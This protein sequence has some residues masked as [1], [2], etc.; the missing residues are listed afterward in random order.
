[1]QVAVTKKGIEHGEAKL[2]KAIKAEEAAEQ[3]I[4]PLPHLL[5]LTLTLT[6]I[7][8][9]QE[10]LS[11]PKPEPGPVTSILSL[12]PPLNLTLSAIGGTERS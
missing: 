6:R 9:A 7:E 10:V 3:A 12:P 4:S 8:A 2:A 11:Q 1:M 5:T